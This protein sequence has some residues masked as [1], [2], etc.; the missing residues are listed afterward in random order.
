MGLRRKAREIALQFFFGYDLQERSCE[1]AALEKDL[2]T[3]C[4]HFEVTR[5]ALPYARELIR[6][7]C[8]H[9]E[10]I[11][12]LLASRSHNW[13]LERMSPVD[14]NILRIAAYEI[15]YVDEVHATVAITEALEIAKR[16]SMEDSA[17]FINGVLDAL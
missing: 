5:K 14:R 16:Y 1:A 8:S 7:I 12:S 17:A 6:G 3:F 11:D 4:R 15:L 10:E 2:D 9:R 13:R